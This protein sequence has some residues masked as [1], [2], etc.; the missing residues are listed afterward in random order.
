MFDFQ[1]DFFKTY[2]LLNEAKDPFYSRNFWAWAKD[3]KYNELC[4][5][6]AFKDELK[7]LGINLDEL[8]DEY[9]MFKEKSSYGIIKKALEEHPDSWALK[10]LQKVWVMQFK[11][12]AKSGSKEEAERRARKD[13][14]EKA[15]R[16]KEQ[17]E[18]HIKA[19]A[20][21][22]ILNENFEDIKQLILDTVNECAA[23][24]AEKAKAKLET[25][26]KR[27][28]EIKTLT[29]NVY[30]DIYWEK[31]G[32]ENYLKQL[33][34]LNEDNLSEVSIELTNFNEKSTFAHI[35]VEVN[36]F[37]WRK[38]T[39]HTDWIHFRIV[40]DEIS[41]RAILKDT[42]INKLKKAIDDINYIAAANSISEADYNETINL[43]NKAKAAQAAADRNEEV[44]QSF[45][46]DLLDICTGG[47]AAAEKEANYWKSAQDGSDGAAYA[48]Y[49]NGAV[50]ELSLYLVH[51]NWR[52]LK[53][54]KEVASWRNTDSTDSLIANLETALRSCGRTG[55]DFRFEII[56]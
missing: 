13:E 35:W 6:V 34:E 43:I 24:T 37:L 32:G 39:H 30:P 45:Y 40:A 3:N 22:K 1:S 36:R 28:A 18:A 29:K 21:W 4:F 27:I 12:D 19:E 49:F 7:E 51:C 50:C 48:G 15:K 47:L 55:K 8:F 16:A 2:E 10:A 33:K 23:K 9:S 52:A 14:E 5:K 46:E 38:L 26:V 42:I 54:D 31:R 56:K 20:D 17:E 11:Y 53:Q 25:S 44:D 41:D